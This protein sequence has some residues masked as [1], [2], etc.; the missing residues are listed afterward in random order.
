MNTQPPLLAP[1]GLDAT[2]GR[3]V[4]READLLHVVV[5]DREGTDDGRDRT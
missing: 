3:L 4:A 1:R 5:Y 2:A